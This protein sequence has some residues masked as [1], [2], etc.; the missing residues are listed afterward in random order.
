MENIKENAPTRFGL[1]IN[2][3]FEEIDDADFIKKNID[4]INETYSMG[5]MGL[6]IYKS[7]GLTDRDKNGDS[8]PLSKGASERRKQ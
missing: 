4:L 6:K 1:F 3:D 5:A 2:I 7:F 8:I